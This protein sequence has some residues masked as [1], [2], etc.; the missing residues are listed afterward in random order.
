MNPS[1][2]ERKN[3]SI[4]G[5]DDAGKESAL[6]TTTCSLSNS[7]CDTKESDGDCLHAEGI[8]G[9]S[10]TVVNEE[11]GSVHGSLAGS[12]GDGNSKAEERSGRRFTR[13][14]LKLDAE[15]GLMTP[16]KDGK[17]NSS[18][19]EG[20]GDDVA[21]RE[22]APAATSELIMS[23][24]D[25]SN[26]PTNLSKKFPSRLKELMDSG[27]L[28]GQKVK[29]QRGPKTRI[30]GPIPG[31]TVL[32]GVVKGSG[33]LCFCD[34]CKGNEV[35]TPAIFEL[36]AKSGN[37]HP[38]E[39]IY[40][41]NGYSLRD[42]MNACKNASL[43]TMDKALQL[44]TGQTSLK[45]SNFCLN[46]RGPMAEEGT[47]ESKVLCNSCLELKDSIVGCSGTGGAE[48]RTP[49]RPSILKSSEPDSA[50][51]HSTTG[52]KSQGRLT[53]KDLRLHKLV[54]EEDI[55]PDGTEVA[56]YSKGEKLLVGYKKGFGIFCSC[57]NS[58]VSPSQ[59]EAHAGWATRRQPYLHI[60]TSNGVSLHELSVSLS[61]GRKISTSE[62]DDLC[63][64]CK[65]GGD[66]LCCDGCPRAYHPE[67]L[68]LPDIPK[69][70]WHCKFC[71]YNYEKEKTVERNANAIAA[72]RVAGVDPIEQI[73]R[74][75]IRIVQ[76]P[77]TDFGGCVLCRKHDF[78]KTFGP[79]TVILCDQCE[80]EYHVG[81]LKDSNM[82][83]L[84][85]LPKGKWFCCSEC[86]KIFSALK[87][88]VV[89]GE[90][91]LPDSSL[92]VIKKKHDEGS[93]ES[94]S[95]DEISWRLLNESIDDS[96]A[97]VSLLNEA[98]AIFHERF[99]MITVDRSTCKGD[100]DL[101]PAIVHG[102]EFKGQELSGMYSAVMLVN[103]VIV[104]AAIVRIFGQ[105]LAE[106]P[107]VAT[108]GKLQGQGY[109]Q[110][111]FTCIEKLLG[112][113]NVKNMILPSAEE[114]ESIWTNKFGFSRMN[115]DE[116]MTCRKNYPVMVFQ[117]TSM[118]RKVVPKCRIIGK[119]EGG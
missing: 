13:S 85:E 38:P 17:R 67:C 92:M 23:K 115:L 80:K 65:D 5:D 27:I 19:V 113:L 11:K 81:C 43:D 20:N 119:S 36:H 1:K 68:S 12:V 57:C 55:L 18:T 82:Q 91:K 10:T 118:L 32:S 76:T 60:Y 88:L 64:I 99:G 29:Y 87:K 95:S 94:S 117:G 4:N 58:E 31:Q 90:E 108:V 104:S 86:N 40:L 96:A 3:C 51:K 97:S 33:I 30:V 61:K 59:F 111:L 53:R 34:G 89:R 102:R 16:E 44:C 2:D 69:G 42:V 114:A 109:F 46:C 106:I 84:K 49:K 15:N 79:R 73:T 50:L 77:D 107:L 39:Y 41:E 110:T 48:K 28:E 75:C 21:S 25:V 22:S 35:V 93:S 56:Y 37:K 116:I 78:Q 74:R 101:I 71:L 14:S 26:S 54:F 9:F 6:A 112:F 70:K 8:D 7:D 66:L 98:V 45:K 83:D 105:E 63:Q 103:H 62:N 52:K 24:N 47:G 72:G 100:R